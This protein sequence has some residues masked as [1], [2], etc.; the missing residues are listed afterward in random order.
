MTNKISSLITALTANPRAVFLLDSA[1]AFLS[2]VQLFVLAK[3]HTFFGMPQPILFLLCAI[4]FTLAIY[5]LCCYHFITNKWR[6]FLTITIASNVIY[7]L[8][9]LSLMVYFHTVLTALGFTYFIL[10]L[11]VLCGIVFIEAK[12]LSAGN[13]AF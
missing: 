12:T 1:G 3:F 11:V 4:A 5:S 13:K 10:E 2:T 8:L 6:T 7:S 9:T